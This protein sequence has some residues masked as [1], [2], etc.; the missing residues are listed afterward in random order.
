MILQLEATKID[1][2]FIYKKITYKTIIF[3]PSS[4]VKVIKKN[5]E[6]FFFFH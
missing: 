6:N 5:I 2:L 4:S 1:T 3:F